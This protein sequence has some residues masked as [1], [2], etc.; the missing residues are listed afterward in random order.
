MR[1]LILTSVFGILISCQPEGGNTH[2]NEVLQAN[3]EENLN[4]EMGCQTL[5]LTPEDLTVHGTIGEES[6]AAFDLRNPCEDRPLI[7]DGVALSDDFDAFEIL[8]PDFTDLTLEPGETIDLLVAFTAESDEIH[9]AD[10][11]I[12][13]AGQDEPASS[14]LMIGIVPTG[15]RSGAAPTAEAG[16]NQSILLGDTATLD[17]SGSSDPEGDSLSYAWTFQSIAGGSGLGNSDISDASTSSPS[18]EPDV[19]GTYRV[20]MVISDGTSTAKD[21]V[22]VTATNGSNSAPV[23]DAG[24]AQTV[25]LGDSVNADGTGSSDADGDSLTYLWT[26]HVTPAASS[27]T[28]FDLSARFSSTP[29]FTPDAA[30]VYRLKLLVS[31]GVAQSKAFVN[32]TVV[33]SNTAPVADAGGSQTVT[34]GNTVTLNGSGSSD[35]DGDSLTYSW[36]FVLVPAASS[37][38]TSDISGANSAIA[39]FV[40][41]VD[42]TYR[43]KLLV[44]DGTDRGKDFA[45]I[46]SSG[47]SGNAAPSAA[48]GPDQ[49]VNVGDT[50]TLNGSGSSDPDGDA[51]TYQWTFSTVPSGSSLT[52]SDISG[53]SSVSASFVTDTA[54][55]FRLRLRVSDG[56]ETDKDFVTATATSTYTYDDDIQPIF[57]AQCTSCHSGSSPSGGLSLSSSV[58]YDNIVNQGSAQSSLDQIE[59]CDTS[60]SYLWHKVNNTQSSVGG[61]GNRMPPSGSGMSSANLAILESW[62]EDCAVEN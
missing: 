43:P 46:T 32:I 37:L 23:A 41:D 59:P 14:N 33:G 44:Q 16:A 22:N 10:I 8:S 4:D 35:A 25:S 12:W 60:A 15:S 5:A 62:I 2:Q 34:T 9:L 17:G 13:I 58:G 52:N 42:G 20:R 56:V 27:L 28:T 61:S 1:K 53:A 26:M 57:N 24:A 18:F 11:D 54:G 47:G 38:T 19:A 48:A 3:P 51:L 49:S 30:G 29:S 21:F 40:P 7:L 31:D 50:V 55:T 6:L 39:T 36:T 45:T